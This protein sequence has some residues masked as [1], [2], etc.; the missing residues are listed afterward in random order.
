MRRASRPNRPS[1]GTR[2]KKAMSS[3]M[4]IERT[5]SRHQLVAAGFGHQD[6]GAGGIPFD[7]LPQSVDVRLERVGG[8][9]GIVAPDFLQQHLARDRPLAGAIEVAQDCGLLLGQADLVALGMEQ[10]L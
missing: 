7:L 9:A 10:E 1:V 2:S 4:V 3:S 8:D 6:G 5:K